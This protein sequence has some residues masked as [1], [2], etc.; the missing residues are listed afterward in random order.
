MTSVTRTLVWLVIGLW[1]SCAAPRLG[2]PAEPQLPQE[3]AQPSR[4]DDAHENIGRGLSFVATW[5]DSFFS[6]PQFEEEAATTLLRLR[7]SGTLTEGE[8]MSYGTQVKVRLQLPHLKERFHLIISS[9]DSDEPVA[10]TALGP[11][12]TAE[13]R[14][15]DTSVA[16]QYRKQRSS[17]FS[18]SHQVGLDLD[19]G[20]N[21]QL[22]SRVRYIIPVAEQSS[23]KLSQAVF[24]ERQEGF[25]E[26]SRIDYDML[27]S[28]HS[29][30]RTTVRGLF[31]ESSD[32]LEWLGMQQWLK[33]FSKKRA[34]ALGLYTNGETRPANHVTEYG[35]FARYRQALLK[36]W[37]FVELKP[38]LYWPR[39]RGF[40]SITAATL[41]FEIQFGE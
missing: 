30:L 27:L 17:R 9:E 26:E 29:L 18:F 20:L 39:D 21:P 38:E 11:P 13:Q 22:R 37:F 2:H 3:T 15:S 34:L 6:D 36:P 14:T 35:L 5:F 16:L 23:L 24:W 1:L 32:G 8:G 40:H 19:G 12:R 7:G 41:T 28:P 33:S 10:A 31:S 25:G 4:L